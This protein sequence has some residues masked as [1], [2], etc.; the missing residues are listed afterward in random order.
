MNLKWEKPTYNRDERIP[1]VP[2]T[3][4]VNMIISASGN[5]YSMIFSI[6]ETQA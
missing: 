1:N 3:E 2:T 4:Y 6:L 5:K